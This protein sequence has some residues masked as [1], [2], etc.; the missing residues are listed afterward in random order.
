MQ[1]FVYA[2]IVNIFNVIS[3]L[4]S[5]YHIGEKESRAREREKKKENQLK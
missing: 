5:I 2:I 3:M 1:L 4:L